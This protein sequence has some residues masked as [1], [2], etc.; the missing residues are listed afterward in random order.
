MEHPL[1][2]LSLLEHQVVEA[3]H[4]HHLI[5]WADQPTD[6]MKWRL[7][8]DKDNLIALTPEVHQAVHYSRDKLT[9]QQIYYLD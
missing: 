6:E 4:V 7:L 3:N 1:C 2:E 8:L 9:S 5:K